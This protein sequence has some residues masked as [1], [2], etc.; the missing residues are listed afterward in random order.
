MEDDFN[1]KC[2]GLNVRSGFMEQRVRA[3]WRPKGVRELAVGNFEPISNSIIDEYMCDSE[4]GRH[5]HRRNF[6]S[7]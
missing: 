5:H 3:M 4:G 2:L 1:G 7:Q 6:R